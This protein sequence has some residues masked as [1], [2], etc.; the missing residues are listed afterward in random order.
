[1][2]AMLGHREPMADIK[3]ITGDRKCVVYCVGATALKISINWRELNSCRG[4]TEL[5]IESRPRLAACWLSRILGS[6][7]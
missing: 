5:D 4:L 6:L 3:L 7:P 2:L 1:M